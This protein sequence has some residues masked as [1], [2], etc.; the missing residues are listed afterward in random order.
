M[1]ERQRAKAD[2]L[3]RSAD[4]YERGADG[5]TATA[6]ALAALPQDEWTVFHDVRWPGRRFANVDHIA[7]GPGGVFVIDSKNWSG[8]VE[9]RDSILR[10]N[11]YQRETTVAAAAEAAIAVSVTIPVPLQ[12]LAVPVLCFV[13]E[14]PLEGWARDVMV[15]ST[16]NIATMLL[17]RPV[18][19][20]QA[21]REQICSGLE[22]TLSAAQQAAPSR[23]G[24]AAAG[25]R[26]VTM[27]R[28]PAPRTPQRRARSTK[29]TGSSRSTKS[30][31]KA[32]VAGLFLVV[33]LLAPQTASSGAQF[34]AQVFVGLIAPDVPAPQDIGQD[35][36]KR[37]RTTSEKGRPQQ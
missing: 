14:D 23:K 9:V 10:Q 35:P 31:G 8:R 28:M 21:S 4:L 1:A 27:P 13:R 22:L 15:C 32:L 33:L 36:K 29:R 18:V 11:G 25:A 2:R 12:C 20:D 34:L 19:L 6:Q 37:E 24:S 7:I 5:E 26:G 30:R 17:S 3:I 16:I